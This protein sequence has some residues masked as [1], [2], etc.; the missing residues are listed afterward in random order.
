MAGIAVRTTTAVRR[1]RMGAAVA[2]RRGAGAAVRL[3]TQ[4][5]AHCSRQQ[6]GVARG[7]GVGLLAQSL[8]EAAC[9]PPPIGCG[10]GS[11]SPGA[12]APTGCHN[13]PHA[14]IHWL[15]GGVVHPS[16]RARR[17][18]NWALAPTFIASMVAD[19]LGRPAG[20][21][22]RAL[23]KEGAKSLESG[24]L[25]ACWAR[26]SQ[27][28]QAARTPAGAST[29]R[30]LH[31]PLLRLSSDLGH[32]EGPIEVSSLP[33]RPTATAWRL[34]PGPPA[35]HCRSCRQARPCQQPQLPPVRLLPQSC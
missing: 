32:R 5:A 2:T 26:C 17:H 18:S 31:R 27:S 25:C 20:E 14:W 13:R 22:R 28:P 19:S 34:P 12:V 29:H 23:L 30:R 33:K 10:A 8:G 15:P 9:L 16:R 6:L 11:H 35:P 3:A 7:G 4:L 21:W 24:A 1:A